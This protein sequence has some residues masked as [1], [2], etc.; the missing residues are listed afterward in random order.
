[1]FKTDRFYITDGGMGTAL[2]KR[3]L[4]SGELPELLNLTDPE[5]VLDIHRLYVK[6]GCDI[7]TANTFGANSLK[8]KSDEKTAEDIEA[9]VALAKKS[10]AEYTSL[11]IGPTGA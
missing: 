11:D 2:Q 10:G 6:A 3:G 5:T 1:M 4:K 7:V 8:L 9:G